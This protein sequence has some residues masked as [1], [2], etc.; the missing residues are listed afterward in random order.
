VDSL[1]S[2]PGVVALVAGAIALLSLA[3][4]VFLAFRVRT[5][6]STQRAVLGDYGE[7]DVVEHASMLQRSFIELRDWVDDTSRGIEQ[8]MGVAE[9]RI[10]S[11]VNHCAVVRYD[12]Y[13][14]MSGR[15]SSSLALL[16]S[17][18]S[19]VVVSSILHRESERVYVKQVVGGRAE[20]ELSPEEQQAVDTAMSDA[21]AAAG[22]S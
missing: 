16:D 19:G 15:Q 14:E 13:G 9:N 18:Q 17:R 2:T 7:R 4:A 6:R 8:R 20:H 11:C 3:L 22:S 12:A 1:S 21:P 10:D 5:L